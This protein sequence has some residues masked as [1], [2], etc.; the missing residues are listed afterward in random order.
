M[1]AL[2]IYQDIYRSFD[3]VQEATKALELLPYLKSVVPIENTRNALADFG[4]ALLNFN[5]SEWAWSYSQESYDPHSA[6]SHFFAARQYADNLVISIS[7]AIIGLVLDPLSV[8][9]P[10]RYQD[11]IRKPRHDATFS[12]QIG[13][14]DGGFSQSYDATFQG[15]SRR[16]FDVSYYL[17][18]SKFDKDGFRENGYSEGNT[19]FYGLGI[20]PDY[21]NGF[22]TYGWTIENKAGEPGTVANPDPDDR[23]E[24]RGAH[25][26]LGYY[27]RF[28]YKNDLLARFAY[29]KLES[30]FINPVPY[31]TGL[32]DIVLSFMQMFGLPETQRFF[33]KGVYD[34]TEIIGGP[35][36]SFAT[37]SSG[38]FA[39]AGLSPLTDTVPRSVD[40]NPL[41]VYDSEDKVL[42]FQ[43]RHLFDIG[44]DHQVTYGVEYV[45]DKMSTSVSYNSLNSTGTIDFCDELL[46]ETVSCS[47]F[48]RYTASRGGISMSDKLKF[49]T[50]YIYDRWSPSEYILIEGGIFYESLEK[51]NDYQ[52]IHPRIGVALRHRNH[53]LRLGFQKWLQPSLAGTLAPISTAGLVVDSR[54]ALSGSRLNDYQARL[55]SRWSE[56]FFTA[57]SA[58]RLELKD[59]ADPLAPIL[60]GRT[61]S[62]SFAVNS[63]LTKNTGVFLRYI[64]TDSRNESGENRGNDIALMPQHAL[65]GGIIW[66]SPHYI[67]SGLSASYIG[68]RYS[69]RENRDLLSEYVT[70]D[71]SLMW[72]PFRK[73]AF[74]N[75]S[76]SNIFDERYETSKGY[77]AAGRSVYLTAQYRF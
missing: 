5:L 54:L 41:R 14:E 74:F 13:S 31:G 77:P 9:S 19:V 39:D 16:P 44:Y 25:V 30:E 1:I 51:E 29:Q 24:Q 8:S 76:V 61:N 63:I 52:G 33:Q 11:I 69:D 62:L 4:S 47:T 68:R 64:Y 59:T 17:S 22:F 49:L 50:A 10:N 65:S 42:A 66:V 7:E 6:N 60:K 26:S 37:D 23:E 28:G 55:E 56:R 38:V 71:F 57:M 35:N 53:I 20:K 45:P 15:Y 21:K 48:S 32:S 2:I 43:T 72:E 73:H 12:A 36:M 58:E 27:H 70:A 40:D 75:L 18:L 34:I 67:K 3:A 46:S